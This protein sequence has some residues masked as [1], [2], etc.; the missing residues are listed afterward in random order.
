MG[1]RFA[2][3]EEKFRPEKKNLPYNKG[4]NRKQVIST[5]RTTLSNL[6]IFFTS[7]FVLEG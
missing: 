2:K 6:F 1:E 7:K 3:K 4:E 5:T